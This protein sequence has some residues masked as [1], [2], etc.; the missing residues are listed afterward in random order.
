M[1]YYHFICVVHCFILSKNNLQCSPHSAFLA[2]NLP[3]PRA[4]PSQ[5]LATPRNARLQQ[6]ERV[7]VPPEYKYKAFGKVNITV[8]DSGGLPWYCYSGEH[9]RCVPLFRLPGKWRTTRFPNIYTPS[10]PPNPNKARSTV[11]TT[12]TTT[13]TTIVEPQEETTPMTTAARLRSTPQQTATQ[14]PRL[15]REL[16]FSKPVF[17]EKGIESN[18]QKANSEPRSIPV[19]VGLTFSKLIRVSSKKDSPETNKGR[20]GWKPIHGGSKLPI[21]VKNGGSSSVIKFKKTIKVVDKGGQHLNFTTQKATDSSK[22]A[23]RNEY[24]YTQV[25]GPRN[26]VPMI[27]GYKEDRTNDEFQ[28]KIDTE[29]IFFANEEGS[30]NGNEQSNFMIQDGQ[31]NNRREGSVAESI[32]KFIYTKFVKP[33]QVR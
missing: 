9:V 33:N 28:S 11:S 30:G 32:N 21:N 8:I 5:N 3:R 25:N 13:L 15:N 7:L 17:Q 22:K 20:A 23:N 2:G 18:L 26:W 27:D 24:T 19:P 16:N 6:T 10:T 12:T 29:A 14:I 31:G 1:R 4:R